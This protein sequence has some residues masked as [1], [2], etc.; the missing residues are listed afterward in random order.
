MRIIV[1]YTKIEATFGPSN[2]IPAGLVYAIGDMVENRLFG[3]AK[4]HPEYDDRLRDIRWLLDLADI[5]GLL[6]TDDGSSS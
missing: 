6:Q 4:P 2:P 1:Y 3:H 5:A